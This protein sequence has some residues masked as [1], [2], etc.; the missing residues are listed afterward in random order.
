[1][2]LFFVFVIIIIIIVGYN[3]YQEELKKEAK[4]KEKNSSQYSN[5]IKFKGMTIDKNSTDNFNYN[6]S[7]NKNNY[8]QYRE[9]SSDKNQ[10]ITSI[11]DEKT[12]IEGSKIIEEVNTSPIIERVVENEG[13]SIPESDINV[14]EPATSYD[15]YTNNNDYYKASSSDF[16]GYDS[17]Y[18]D[19]NKY[20][21]TSITDNELR[22]ETLSDTSSYVDIDLYKNSSYDDIA[23]RL[24]KELNLKD[25]YE[26]DYLKNNDENK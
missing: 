21:E 24:K 3:K 5:Y 13:P 9:D 8:S 14:V 10:G 18:F 4:E 15:S 20:K 23:E 22:N 17:T 7:S 12:I 2:V 1:M 26:S 6:Q 25:Y 16:S 19:N 11:K